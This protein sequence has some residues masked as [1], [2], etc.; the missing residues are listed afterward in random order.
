MEMNDDKFL[1][2]LEIERERAELERQKAELMFQRAQA[3][4]KFED[5]YNNDEQE[6][7]N[8][9]ELDDIRIDKDSSSKQKY[10]LLGFILVLLFLITLVT[11]KLISEPEKANNYS[12]NNLIDEQKPN[13]TVEATEP[14]QA[15][16]KPI[17]DESSN[18]AIAPSTEGVVMKVVEEKAPEVQPV[19]PSQPIE[20]KNATAEKTTKIDKDIFG[21]E[22][23]TASNKKEMQKVEKSADKETKSKTQDKKEVIKKED[24][25][26]SDNKKDE[27]KKTDTKKEDTKKEDTKKSEVKKSDLKKPENKKDELKQSDL[28][29]NEIKKDTKKSTQKQNTISE[30]LWKQTA[31]KEEAKTV[32]NNG[33]FIQ[34]GV[35]SATP[36]QQLI[37][38][39]K[40]NN[41]KYT[42][43]KSEIDGK[44][45]S[46]LFIGGYKSEEKA[47]ED[48]AKVRNEINPKAFIPK[49]Q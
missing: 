45:V 25:K 26:K 31:K 29:N 22:K 10:I 13:A 27:S 19:Q 38:I 32:N 8:Y 17:N 18:N 11:I 23:A 21:I 24:A 1:R 14:S 33:I 34:V 15:S 48:L 40:K 49:G 28:K 39:L 44:T 46:K 16:E 47:K 3:H 4:R 7:L 36:D 42:F 41:F 2:N 12:Q 37:D 9:Q 30:D 43:R 5:T 20:T 6:N 35:F